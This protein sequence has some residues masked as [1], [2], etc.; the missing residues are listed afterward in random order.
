MTPAQSDANRSLTDRMGSGDI[1]GGNNSIEKS[2]HS[3]ALC[4][5]KHSLYGNGQGLTHQ[6]LQVPQEAEAQTLTRLLPPPRRS[7]ASRSSCEVPLGFSPSGGHAETRLEQPA[8]VVA[9]EGSSATLLCTANTKVSYIHWYIHQEGKAPQRLLRLAMY[10][11]DV[12][13]DSVEKVDKVNAIEA[14]DGYSCILLLLKLEKRDE[15]LYYCAAW[16]AHSTPAPQVPEQKGLSP[17]ALHAWHLPPAL[18]PRSCPGVSLSTPDSLNAP[19]AGPLH[20]TLQAKEPWRAD[21]ERDQEITRL[22]STSPRYGSAAQEDRCLGRWLNKQE[23]NLR[24]KKQLWKE[25]L[26]TLLLLLPLTASNSN[27]K[28]RKTT[29]AAQEGLLI[30][31]RASTYGAQKAPDL[32]ISVADHEEPQ[33]TTEKPE[34]DP[35]ASD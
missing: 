7:P 9:R 33:G 27:Q 28:I 11:S 5:L 19:S 29:D 17:R 35:P 4:S 34:P 6:Y 32:L 23:E 12:Q 3:Q 30:M 21:S 8:V 22:R 2:C 26:S 24:T 1:G 15:G 18:G 31:P 10:Q 16:E 20:R 14:K 13:W 25:Q